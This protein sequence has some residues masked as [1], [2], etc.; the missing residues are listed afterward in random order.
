MQGNTKKQIKLSVHG[1]MISI[2][3]VY[4]IIRIH[5]CAQWELNYE[6]GLMIV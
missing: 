4:R 3:G 5:L 6:Y 1:E 2:V